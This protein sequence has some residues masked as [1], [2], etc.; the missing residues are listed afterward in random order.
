[1]SGRGASNG[2]APREG[3]AISSSVRGEARGI[4]EVTEGEPGEGVPRGVSGRGASNG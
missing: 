1:M 3:V 4:T 2:R